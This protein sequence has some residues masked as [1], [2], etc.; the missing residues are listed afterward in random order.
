MKLPS[1]VALGIDGLHYAL[2]K[3]VIEGIVKCIRLLLLFCISVTA[4]ECVLGIVPFHYAGRLRYL[5]LIVGWFIEVVVS[6]QKF[7]QLVAIGVEGRLTLA[8]AVGRGVQVGR[9]LVGH[10]PRFLLFIFK[11][12][13]IPHKNKDK[14]HCPDITPSKSY[15]P[16]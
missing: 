14:Y 4:S 7:D 2:V 16:R 10:L 11:L 9:V 12:Y 8:E 3:T 5:L 6:V 1:V 13:A 15:F